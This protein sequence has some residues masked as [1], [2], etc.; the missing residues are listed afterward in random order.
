M[1][2]KTWMPFTG[3]KRQ[4]RSPRRVLSQNNHV[5]AWGG[6]AEWTQLDMEDDYDE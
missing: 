3:K 1:I 2:L 5:V 4:Q 6:G